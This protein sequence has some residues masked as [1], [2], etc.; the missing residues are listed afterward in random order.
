MSHDSVIS[1]LDERH[2]SFGKKDE[3]VVPTDIPTST[4][5]SVVADV[6]GRKRNRE[7]DDDERDACPGDE[8][9]SLNKCFSLRLPLTCRC[10][11]ASKKKGSENR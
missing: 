5:T 7:M 1:P 10:P 11:E 2:W 8:V 4:S 9:C 3:G 6:Q